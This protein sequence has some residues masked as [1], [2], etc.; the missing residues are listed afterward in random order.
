MKKHPAIAVLEF[1]DIAVGLVATDAMLKRSPIA[2]LKCGT[3]SRGRFLTLLGGTTASVE[4]ACHEG[5]LQGGESVL[6][7]V[8]LADVHP[9]LYDA[10]LG[11]RRPVGAGSLAIIE[12]STV[13][14]NVRAAELALKGTPV[15]LVELRLADAGLSGKGLSIVHGELHDVEAAVEIAAS[16]LRDAGVEAGFR[17]I[18]APHEALAGHVGAGTRFG[19]AALLEL[20]GEGDER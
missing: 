20:D 4:E 5:L 3:I 17:I 9:Q 14:S 11:H 15:D 16:F 19:S 7:H 10:I 1:R 8:L 2:F 12:T 18:P 6:D 13:S